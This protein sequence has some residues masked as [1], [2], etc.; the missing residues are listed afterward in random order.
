MKEYKIEIHM[1]SMHSSPCGKLDAKTLAEGYKEAGYDMLVVTEHFSRAAF[2]RLGRDVHT[3]EPFLDGY[4]KVKA[5][6]E[7]LGMKVLLGAEVR[8]DGDDNDYLCYGWD[9]E[10]FSDP[11]AIFRMGLEEFYRQTRGMGMWLA[12]AHPYRDGCTPAPA[13]F[14]DAVEVHNAHP[15]HDSRNYLAR[16]YAEKHGKPML[17]GSDCHQKPDIGLSGIWTKE[18]PETEKELADLLRNGRYRMILPK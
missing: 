17:S 6:A 18:L 10:F 12:Q 7:P 4:H 11:D 14:L 16:A 8:F 5:A 1:H 3:F 15:R 13:E 9:Q 2:R